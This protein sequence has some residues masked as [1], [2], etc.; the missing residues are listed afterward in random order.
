MGGWIE[1]GFTARV[2]WLSGGS[3]VSQGL[4]LVFV[5][6]IARQTDPSTYGLYA[7]VAAGVAAGARLFTLRLELAVPAVRTR[8]HALESATLAALFL[9]ALTVVSTSAVMASAPLWPRG[10]HPGRALTL[11]A[12]LAALSF[13]LH[14]IARFWATRLG[15]ERRSALAQMLRT[16]VTLGAQLLLLTLGWGAL[17]LVL[18]QALGFAAAVAFMLP[19]WPWRRIARLS[20]TRLRK[21][22]EVNR[23][24]ARFSTPSMVISVLGTHLPVYLLAS[25]F[26]LSLSG[27]FALVI[28]VLGAPAGLV[29]QAMGLVLFSEVS[30]GVHSERRVDDVVGRIAG[31]LFPIAASI[32]VAVA[33]LADP[34]VVLTL[35]RDWRLAAPVATALSAWF[36][37]AFVVTA[38]DGLPLVMGRQRTL[39][40]LTGVG[41]VL[42][43]GA[44]V[45]G[46]LLA[47][48]T[49][50]LWGYGLAGASVS[51]ATLVWFLRLAGVERSWSRRFWLRSFT[52]AAVL[53][54]VF[55]GLERT[56]LVLGTASALGLAVAL[57]LFR[58]RRLVRA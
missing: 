23:D 11:C 56:H 18:G 10:L 55:W 17:G 41:T 26:G 52:E 36:A 9:V 57:A 34:V 46:G 13:G 42:R 24:Y 35:G 2:A 45:A 28:R 58:L 40:S 15:A 50:A 25:F 20:V 31:G 37:L 39:L 21:R 8:L 32:F 22:F 29:S 44:L 49:L 5:P 12:G 38:L 14:Q 4:L 1:R 16:G 51:L 6:L 3:A 48:R 53:G 7:L 43:I 54:G 27:S 30:K 33:V 47:S 19:L